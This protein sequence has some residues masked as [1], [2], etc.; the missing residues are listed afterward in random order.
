MDWGKLI[1]KSDTACEELDF[2]SPFRK[3]GENMRKRM[4]S[5]VSFCLVLCLLLGCP[6]GSL[7]GSVMIV[8]GSTLIEGSLEGLLTLPDGF[9]V[10]RMEI[11]VASWGLNYGSEDWIVYDPAM[12]AC[13]L[14]EEALILNLP[15]PED[16]LTSADGKT[17][18]L[19]TF[20]EEEP[21]VVYD[22][23]LGMIGTMGLFP[24]GAPYPLPYSPSG[25]SPPPPPPPSDNT[26]PE[27][28][29]TA[30]PSGVITEKDVTFAFSGSDNRTATESL[31]YTCRLF[32]YDASY[33]SY[34][35]ATSKTY[36]NLPN[37]LYTFYVAAKDLAQ[38]VDPTPASQSFEV[39]YPYADAYG[40]VKEDGNVDLLDAVVALQVC[41]GMTPTE[42]VNKDADVN[43]DESIGLAEVIYILQ[44]VADLR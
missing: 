26:P 13:S 33:S 36:S 9:A 22:T 15:D 17:G 14:Y 38:N 25:P 19:T 29:I 20:L 1:A 41:A 10:S 44:K 42:E 7:A 4:A 27:T 34:S 31:V 24:A 8:K 2:K 43:G 32:G 21:Y 16:I 5:S 23:D 6:T 30:G 3:K 11:E 37:G 39:N 40:D 35:G 18:T 12:A 28:I